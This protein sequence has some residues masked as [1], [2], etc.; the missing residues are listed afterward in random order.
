M[1]IAFKLGNRSNYFTVINIDIS[2]KS[3]IFD[4]CMYKDISLISVL[5]NKSYKII[6]V[7]TYKIEF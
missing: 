3:V 1:K 2:T 4:L 7:L 5:L 6:E